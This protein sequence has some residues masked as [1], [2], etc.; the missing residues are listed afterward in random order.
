MFQE[1]DGQS[2]FLMSE[3]VIKEIGLKRGPELNLKRM[4]KELKDISAYTQS[5]SLS[6]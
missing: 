1:F 5:A 4:L 3:E 6:R 2:F